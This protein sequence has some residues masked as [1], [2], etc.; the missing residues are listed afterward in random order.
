MMRRRI[1][2]SMGEPHE[3][4]EWC[5]RYRHTAAIAPAPP[6]LSPEQF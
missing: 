1:T 4:Y 6:R 2:G 5:M 3:A